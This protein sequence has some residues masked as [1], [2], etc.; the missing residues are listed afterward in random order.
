MSEPIRLG[1][2]TVAFIAAIVGAAAFAAGRGTSPTATTSAP[3]EVV[4]TSGA[5]TALA[6][7]T[8]E[9]GE[10]QGDLPLGHP[11]V[12]E[13]TP[14]TSASEPEARAIDWKAPPRWQ[15]VPNTN[16]M[17]LAT[18]RIP[19]PDGGGAEAELSIMQA[20]GTVD[21]NVDRWIGQFDEAARRTAKRT[22]RDIRGTRV[23]IVEVEGTF[24]DGMRKN[25]GPQEGWAL[26]GAIVGTPGM[27]HFLKMTGPAKTVRHARG[28][29]DALV[30]SIVV[31]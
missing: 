29:L 24:A 9:H 8:H 18:Y 20:G 27:A 16:T 10:G 1:I 12:A 5:P 2:P 3:P 17:R 7:H 30:G 21:A 22:T 15:L 14:A 26:L 4:T 13:G 6:P 23:T 28:E 31:R 25:A 11:P 19:A